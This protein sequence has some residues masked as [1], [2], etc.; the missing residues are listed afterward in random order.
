MKIGSIAIKNFK[1]FEVLSLNLDQKVNYLI[2]KNG[3]G[4]S[5]VGIDSVIACLQG[6]AQQG[7]DG[8]KPLI[9][10]RF[11]VIN[12]KAR[13]ANIV[14]TL[15]EENGNSIDVVRNITASGQTLEFKGSKKDVELNQKW[16]NNLFNEF[17][18]APKRFL[19]LTSKEQAIRLGIDTSTFDAEIKAL[20]T[21][22]TEINAVYRSF[23][24]ITE[25]QKVD[26]VEVSELIA[27]KE[28]AQKE[29]ATARQV[30][31][32]ALNNKYLDNIEV[33]KVSKKEWEDSKAVIDESVRIGNENEDKKLLQ[34]NECVG[35]NSILLHHGCESKEVANFL[36]KLKAF[37]Q[38]K[39]KAT[40]LYAPEPIYRD[41]KPDDKELVSFDEETTTLVSTID[42][43]IQDANDTNQKA[44]LYTQFVDNNTKKTAKE[45]ELKA[46]MLLQKEK[47][48]ERLNYIKAFNLPFG[49]L[50]IDDDG[51]LLKEGR[52]IKEPHFSTGELLKMVPV[53]ISTINPEL[54]YVFLQDFNLMDED[55]QLDTIE[56]LTGLGYQLVIEYVGKEAI[57]DK[58]CIILKECKIV[59]SYSAELK[60][61]LAA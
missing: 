46:N 40:D 56:Y 25:V 3:S 34:Y 58:N 43:E 42:K 57:S 48:A 44:L 30:I 4:K 21:K 2:G 55:K 31:T 5:G 39:R 54:K 20:K 35:A 61:D 36:A 26:K 22:Y 53:L 28:A 15:V 1:G 60:P 49:N 47:E 23:G 59:E 9:S 24:E 16:L 13:A 50:S 8:N 38:D 29:R 51:Q 11:R 41:P 6:V 32:S 7:K 52:P 18:I 17:L 14:V 10:E 45:A 33:N 37:L 27:K 19:E 12:P